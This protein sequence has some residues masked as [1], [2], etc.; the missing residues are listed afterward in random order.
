[1]HAGLFRT[2]S[3]QHVDVFDRHVKPV[4]AGIGNPQTVVGRAADRKGLEAFIATDA[5]LDMD[6]EIAFGYLRGVGDKGVGLAP[7][8]GRPHQAVAEQILFRLNA[9]R[10]SRTV[11]LASSL[12]KTAIAVL[13]AS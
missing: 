1:M 4:V 12:T 5:V 13:G 6:D 3:R 9:A 2:E 7:L 10:F 8:A 11:P